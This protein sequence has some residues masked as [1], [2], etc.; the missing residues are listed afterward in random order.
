M[1]MT[2][3]STPDPT[4]IPFAQPI[5]PQVVEK[6]QRRRFNAEYKLRILKETDQCDAGQVGAILRREGL[7][8]SHLSLWRQQ[9]QAGQ[10]AALGDSKRGRPPVEANPLAAEI[11]A[12]RR[13]NAQ[14]GKRL[15]QAERIIEVQKKISMLLEVTQETIA[16]VRTN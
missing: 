13:E 10:L 16:S 2:T 12:L 6:A 15:E 3:S 1:V 5:D 7:Y 9:R 11:E 4:K 14:L 8:S